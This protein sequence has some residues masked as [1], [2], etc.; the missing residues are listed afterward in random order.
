VKNVVSLDAKRREKEEQLQ[1]GERMWGP[2]L[3]GVVKEHEPKGLQE[4][5]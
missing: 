1:P 2:Q 3:A 5:E 4:E